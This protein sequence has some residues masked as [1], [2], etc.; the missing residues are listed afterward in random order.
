[1]KPLDSPQQPA[2]FRQLLELSVDAAWVMDGERL[3]DCNDQAAALL[4]HAGRSAVLQ[5]AVCSLSPESQPDGADSRAR[6]ADL[7]ARARLAGAQRF[8]WALMKADGH[9]LMAELSLASLVALAPLQPLAVLCTLRERDE[10]GRAQRMLERERQ[11]LALSKMS[12][13]WFWQQDSEYRFTDFSGAFATEFTPAAGAMG[14]RRWELQIDLTPEQWAA[15]R[16]V[17]DARKPFRDFQYPILDERGETRW[18]SI[19]GDPLCDERGHFTG[20]HG[21]GRNISAAKKAEAELR[22]AA[23]AFESQEGMAI[24]V[25][26]LRLLDVNR[27]YCETLGYSAAEL[28]GQPTS[29][30]RSDRHGAD[31]Y[32]QMWDAVKREGGWHGEIWSRRK[33]GEVYPAWLVL[34]SVKDEHGSVTRYVASHRDITQRK[35]DE[36]RIREL[37]FFDQLT[38]LP[39]RTLLLD[40]LRQAQATN[41]RNASHGALLFIDLDSFKT[42]NDTRGHD[43]GDLLLQQVAGRL[44]A[45][46]RQEDS[47]GR[48]GGDEFV[49]LLA[50]LS[51][52]EREAAA[53]AE[54][55]AEKVLAALD[56]I[57]VLGDFDY[58][59]SASI[60]VTLFHGQ[61]VPVEELMKQADMAM[62]KSKAA[63]RNT[64]R[65]FDP[66]MQA[67][68]MAR[69]ALEAEMRRAIGGP[70]FFLQFQPQV[71]AGGKISGA[72]VLLRYRDPHRGL[73]SPAEFIPLAE[74]TG[75]ILPLGLWVL[76]T[77]CAQLAAWA[78]HP[79]LGQLTVAVNVSAHQIHSPDFVEQVLNTL[80]ST[81]ANPRRLK[82]ELT[83]SL[84]VANVEDTIAK[85]TALKAHGVG[86]SLDDFGTGYSSLAYLKRMPLDQLKIDRSFVH[87]L[88]NDPHDAAI[89]KTIIALARSMGLEVIAEGVETEAERDFL[90]AAGCLSYQ[91]FLFSRPV[92]VEDFEDLVTPSKVSLSAVPG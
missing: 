84:L 15:H 61:Q 87:D 92:P 29:L 70:Q 39:N 9:V 38:G 63:G 6:L 79:R 37:A 90:L 68:V 10:S 42:L 66:A 2:P 32:H 17:L 14:R 58:H 76:K 45:N 77:A 75:L 27:A 83:E 12:S 26:D 89:A 82:L 36:E 8:E 30:F 88:H 34:S 4:G 25:A 33:N 54:I 65:F 69:A 24:I 7:V 56:Q 74:E 52:G 18:Y 11:F 40:R 28:L 49:V 5:H 47:V 48:L 73:I 67:V 80:N 81:G 23:S 19:N 78:D 86:F 20:Y 62:Y 43:M 3:L 55:A 16:A 21:T 41:A 1:M 64:V 57:Y 91:G 59:C 35:Q 22:V 60:G 72:E 46:L 31:F 85:M 51:T 13:D 53:G 50:N 44:S 71:G